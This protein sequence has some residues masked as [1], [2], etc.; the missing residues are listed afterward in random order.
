MGADNDLC[1]FNQKDTERLKI[2]FISKS[3]YNALKDIQLLKEPII[4]TELFVTD[5]RKSVRRK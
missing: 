3:E 2:L 1:E 5:C 4:F